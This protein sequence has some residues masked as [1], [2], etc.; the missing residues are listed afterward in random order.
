MN[1]CGY[2]GQILR[3]DLTTGKIKKEP[4][5]PEM[6]KQYIG[7]FGI[8][9]RLLYDAVKPGTDALSPGNAIVCS[10]GAFS[11]TVLVGASKTDWTMKSPLTHMAQTAL[12]SGF[13]A[14]LK[15]AGYDTI[16]VTGKAD[17][18]CYL[19]IFDGDVKINDAKDLW[20]KDT[21]QAT[22]A[23]WDRHGGSCAIA[24]IGPAGEKLVR[25]SVAYVD[26]ISTLGKEG[27]G[28]VFGSKNLKAIVVNGTR[29]FKVSDTKALLG[30]ADEIYNRFLQDPLLKEWMAL[31]TTI[32]LENYGKIGFVL[33]KNAREA[34]PQDRLVERFSAKAFLP[35]REIALPCT[36]CPM[37]CKLLYNIREGEFAGLVTQQSCNVG[38][39]GSYGVH[40]DLKNYNQVIK[41]HD[42][43]NRLGLDSFVTAESLDFVMD[44]QEKGIITKEVTDGVELKRD[45]N[46][47]LFWMDKIAKREGFGDVLA[48]GY[49][50][51]FKALGKDLEKLTSQRRYD[52]IDFDARANFGTEAFGTA[53]GFTGPHT[54]FALGPTVLPGRKQDN[55]QR[56]AGNI[57]VPEEAMGRIFTGPSGLN[58][59]RFCRYIENWNAALHMMGICN[60]PPIVRLY[61]LPLLAELYHIVTGIELEPADLLAAGERVV[62][63]LRAF[64]IREGMTREDDRLPERYFTEPLVL[65]SGEEKW[66]SDYSRTKRLTKDDL[67]HML[68]DYYEERGWDVKT[69]VPTRETLVGLGLKDVAA[70]LAAK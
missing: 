31:G 11:G 68:D 25:T 7:G 32:A 34:Y 49:E 42:T 2:A 19:T 60:R 16:V 13:G 8:S 17:R 52:K 44:L 65:S 39:V 66:I 29:G 41:C 46:T 61:S 54:R 26:K 64:N 6:A 15:W 24:C 40:F 53:I 47:V 4:L 5:E 33:W 20:G 70:D 28:A 48:E 63:L 3:V 50:G 23:I 9:S 14:R 55:L 58:E 35:Y 18:P 57:G 30:K 62:T 36:G 56:Y 21:Y 59:A 10:A 38:A 67:E 27:S 37:S 45:M 12:S 51:I 69:G 43:G 1:M 22:D